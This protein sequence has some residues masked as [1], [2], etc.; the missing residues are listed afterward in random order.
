MTYSPPPLDDRPADEIA[1]VA[2]LARALRASRE[3][4]GRASPADPSRLTLR[5]LAPAVLSALAA[6]V[7]LAALA[8]LLVSVP[9]GWVVLLVLAAVLGY[10]LGRR[11]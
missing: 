4:A 7:V 6:W 1:E 5:S 8:A 9:G 3:I 11:L 2:V 10:V